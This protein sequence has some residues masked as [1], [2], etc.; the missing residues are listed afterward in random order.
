MRYLL[1][2]LVN[3]HS[4]CLRSK[5]I[6]DHPIWKRDYPWSRFCCVRELWR[7]PHALIS[8]S[9]SGLGDLRAC[10]LLLPASFPN[11]WAACLLPP[12]SF[13]DCLPYLAINI[14]FFVS[15]LSFYNSLLL[16]DFISVLWS[17]PATLCPCIPSWWHLLS[18]NNTETL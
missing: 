17:Y 4:K 9:S 18:L 16:R 7:R 1:V 13:L 12:A 10:C 14:T 15:F 8:G 6:S 11:W 2:F 5:T 3:R